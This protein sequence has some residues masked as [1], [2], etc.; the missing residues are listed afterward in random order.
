[1]NRFQSMKKFQ[2]MNK[3]RPIKSSI[4]LLEIMLNILLFAILATICIQLFFKAR[5]LS[6]NAALLDH[7]A[8]TC[9]SI[10]EVYQSDPDSKELILTFYPDAIELNETILFYF[11]ENHLSCT[12]EDSSY[13]AVLEYDRIHHTAEISFYPK[14]GTSLIYALEVSSYMP[15]TLGEQKGGLTP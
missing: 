8:A 5:I 9:T 6:K 13:R 12:E 15:Q 14:D 1:M 10:A 2:P 7:A 11:D 4:F 3:Y